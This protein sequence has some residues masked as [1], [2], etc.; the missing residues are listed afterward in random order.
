MHNAMGN[1][2]TAIALLDMPHL[3]ECRMPS[4]T[5]MWQVENGGNSA[6]GAAGGF[7][8]QYSSM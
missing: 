6:A 7:V 5:V 2:C 1:W 3:V 4:Y 8:C